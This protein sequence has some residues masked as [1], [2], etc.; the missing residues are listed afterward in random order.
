[1]RSAIECI[2]DHELI[3]IERALELRSKHNISSRE[4]FSCVECGMP[5][6]PHMA[7][8]KTSHPAHFEHFK[9]NS[10]CP[11]SDS[12]EGEDLISTLS[13]PVLDEYTEAYIT[14]F[15][16]F[17]PSTWGCVGFSKEGRRDT[18]IRET[19]DPFVMVIY[20]TDNAGPPEQGEVDYRGKLAGFY[21][22]S[23]EKVDR[24]EATDK[25]HHDL[26]PEKWKYSLKAIKAY[27][28]SPQDRPSI[29][30]F[31]PSIFGDKT[32]RSISTNGGLLSNSAFKMLKSYSFRETPVYGNEADCS[33]NVVSPSL[34]SDDKSSKGYVAG[35][36]VNGS[37]YYVPPEGE[38]EK[39]LYVLKME[40]DVDAFLGEPANG[41]NIYKIGLS[42][43]PESREKHFNRSMPNGQFIWKV[44]RST[45]LDGDEPYPNFKTAEKGERAMKIFLS[46]SSRWLGGE[47]YLSTEALITES[48]IKGKVEALRFRDELQASLL[49]DS[50]KSV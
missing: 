4:N 6:R 35:G 17:S 7:S 11:Y 24:R 15:W 45:G 23:H 1:M 26:E 33:F 5:V 29:R 43:S 22:V 25:K 13:H 21:L 41:K 50:D 44:L 2:Y 12:Y 16:G 32:Y 40:G 37:G 20:V 3:S 49:E 31:E 48:W 18:I 27:E 8:D 34:E 46:N 36:N 19:S 38:S 42:I 28:I 39:E 14:S 30:E 10:A 9:R 47:F